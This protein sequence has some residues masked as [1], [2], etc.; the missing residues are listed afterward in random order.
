MRLHGPNVPNLFWCVD[1]LQV[2]GAT[3]RVRPR[4]YLLGLPEALYVM[5]FP[6]EPEDGGVMVVLKTPPVIA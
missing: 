1:K 4:A 2:P 6:A 5:T 3:P